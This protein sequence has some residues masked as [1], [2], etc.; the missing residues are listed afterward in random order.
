MV[1]SVLA[2]SKVFGQL[3]TFKRCRHCGDIHSPASEFAAS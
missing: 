3:L 1:I 2:Y